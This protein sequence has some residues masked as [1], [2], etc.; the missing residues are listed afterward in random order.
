MN[1]PRRSQIEEAARIVGAVMR[2]T[3]EIHWPLLSARCRAEVWVKHENHTPVGA[4]KLRGGIVYMKDLT[5]S[6]RRAAGVIAATRGNHGQ[7][8]AYAARRHGLDATI[9]VPHGNSIEKNAAM[10]AI[11]A[12]LIEHGHDFQA[13]L[14]FARAQ[15]DARGLTMVPSFHEILVLGVATCG[16]EFLR[17]APELDSVYVPIGLGSGICGMIAARE[18]LGLRTKVVGVVASD[19]PAYALSF[20]AGRPVTTASADTIADGVACRVPE[21]EA[22]E[23]INRYAERIVSVTDEE[24]TAAMRHYFTDTH[25]LAEGAGAAPLAA[26]LQERSRMA[27]RCAGLVLSGG[28]V[29]RPLYAR[30]IAQAP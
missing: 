12:Q 25:N 8:I 4:F 29:D 15:A 18:A 10:R 9:V 26:L 5:R 11:G 30:I 7:S 22:V 24:I 19:A 28:N 23:M 20:A 14:E 27:G 21:P 3:P 17:T 6:P 1:L 2:P 16:L 13:A